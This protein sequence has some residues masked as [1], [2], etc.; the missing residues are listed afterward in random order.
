MRLYIR[1]NFVISLIA[2]VGFSIMFGGIFLQDMHSGYYPTFLG[3]LIYLLWPVVTLIMCVKDYL[4]MRKDYI[5]LNAEGLTRVQKNKISR[6]TWDEFH[7]VLVQLRLLGIVDK[8][9]YAVCKEIDGKSEK[10]CLGGSPKT[11]QFIKQHK[12]IVL[13]D[14]AKPTK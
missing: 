14:I 10:Y 7:V 1:H 9:L 5:E 6:Y 8:T 3:A 13:F 4:G 11:M 12:E 2:F